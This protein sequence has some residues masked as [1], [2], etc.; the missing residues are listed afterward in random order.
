MDFIHLIIK[1]AS[2]PNSL[3]S[4]TKM[5]NLAAYGSVAGHEHT[6]ENTYLLTSP[7]AAK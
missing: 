2:T 4:R 5:Y 3:G 6:E 7:E 1:N